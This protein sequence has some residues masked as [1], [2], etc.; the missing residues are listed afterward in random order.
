MVRRGSGLGERRLTGTGPSPWKGG[1]Q[2]KS[3]RRLEQGGLPVIYDRVLQF[4]GMCPPCNLRLSLNTVGNFASDD[5]RPGPLVG[6]FPDQPKGRLTVLSVLPSVLGIK[7]LEWIRPRMAQNVK[8]LSTDLD[9]AC[10]SLCRGSGK[11]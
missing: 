8:R 10:R 4:G 5:S 9:G 1:G 3:G 7:H 11:T 6:R 2:K